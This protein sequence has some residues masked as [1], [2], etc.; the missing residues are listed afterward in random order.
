MIIINQK[1]EQSPVLRAKL[2]LEVQ[3]EHDFSKTFKM[4]IELVICRIISADGRSWEN[5]SSKQIC[6]LM[7]III[8]TT[9]HNIA[10]S[11]VL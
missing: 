6:P 9:V 11:L 4:I 8:E 1:Y 10:S 2:A 5:T 3:M 7:T